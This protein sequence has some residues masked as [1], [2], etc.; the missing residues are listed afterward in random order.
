MLDTSIWLVRNMVEN[1]YCC[2]V[3]LYPE[4]IKMFHQK[5]NKNKNKKIPVGQRVKNSLRFPISV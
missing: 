4:T 5:E 3:Q 1:F 2:G